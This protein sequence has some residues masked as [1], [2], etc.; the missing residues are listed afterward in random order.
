MFSWQNVNFLTDLA[1]PTS[2]RIWEIT[3]GLQKKQKAPIQNFKVSLIYRSNAWKRQSQ[4]T[5]LSWKIKNVL[6]EKR[7]QGSLS[8]SF[9]RD[10][11]ADKLT[12][13]FRFIERKWDWHE[14]IS[15]INATLQFFLLYKTHQIIMLY[16]QQYSNCNFY[17]RL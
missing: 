6:D 3:P 12:R 5:Q 11:L 14:P 13:K 1:L 8:N 7:I 17:G 9:I 15:G 10:V 4:V 16:F 2:L